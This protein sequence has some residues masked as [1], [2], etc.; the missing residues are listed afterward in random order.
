MSI[1]L[2]HLT[3]N[4]VRVPSGKRYAMGTHAN[5]KAFDRHEAMLKKGQGGFFR[6]LS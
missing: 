5:Y 4:M 2:E 6:F 1:P 3:D